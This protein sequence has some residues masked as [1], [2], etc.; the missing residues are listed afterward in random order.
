MLTIFFLTFCFSKRGTI[1]S[2]QTDIPV[3][4]DMAFLMS[5]PHVSNSAIYVI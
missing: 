2:R 5:N 3:N 1:K 4:L